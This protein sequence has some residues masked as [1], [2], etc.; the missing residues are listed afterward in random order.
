MNFIEIQFPTDI[1]YGA[2]GGPIY[3]TDVV[4][5]FSGYEQRNSNWKNARSRY[6]IATGVKTE[7]QWQ[8]L[9]AFFRARKGKAIGFR[10]KDW[11]DY[12][13]KAQQIGIGDDTKTEFQLVKIYTSGSVIVPR[14]I[15]K[16]VVGTVKVHTNNNLRGT[17]S[18][19][20]DHTTGIISFDKAPTAG[21]IIT[22]NFEFDVPVR[23]DTD[24]LQISMDS[25]KSGS[26]NN[27]PLIEI[28]I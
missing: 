25:F 24:E 16:P 12:S 28:R 22:A 14:E 18:Y 3:S 7:A 4:T 17:T 15:K 26:W 8:A 1:S 5:M 21:V 6:N 27:I 19:L 13:A 20:I 10:F 2:T 11:S 23:F 9:I